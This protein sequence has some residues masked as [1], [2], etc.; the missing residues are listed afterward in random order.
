[1]SEHSPEP[2]ERLS[3]ALRRS[4]Y[5]EGTTPTVG[6]AVPAIAMPMHLG[7]DALSCTVHAAGAARTAFAK[8][9]RVGALD[10]FTFDG[11][12]Q[13]ASRAGEA[14]LAPRLIEADADNLFLLFEPAP[15]NFRMAQARDAQRREAKAAIL[16]A[17]K[18]WHAQPLLSRDL[19]PFDLAR[20]YA[21]RVSAHL[22]AATAAQFPYKGSVPFAGLA[23]WMARIGAA[24]AAAGMDR[25]PI[26]AEN[27]VSNILLGP[28]N[29]VLLVDF[30]R[31]ANADPLYDLGAL[32]LDLCRNDGERMEMIEMYAGR[33]DD[34]SFARLKL[35]AIVDDFL[36]GCWALLAELNPAM[37]GPELLKYASNRFLRASH[38]LAT[39]DVP[40]LLARI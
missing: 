13:A 38:H 20:D 1:M 15:E 35:Y 21:A 36:W 16:A 6:D 34:G 28:G 8:T 11:A 23:Q 37:K 19:S 27:T 2:A 26:H 14:G 32:S 17:K 3:L 12:A 40:T 22:S 7:L 9:Y 33:A 31:A 5:F 10:P 30:D 39:F 4:S 25:K 29:A 18:A 24:F